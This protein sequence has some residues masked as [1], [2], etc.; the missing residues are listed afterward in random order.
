MKWYHII[1]YQ[2]VL[3]PVPLVAGDY[4]SIVNQ[5][6]PNTITIIG[7]SHKHPE[8]ITLF[9]SIISD[10]L[11][12]N[13]CLTVGLEIASNQQT[14]IDKLKQGRAVVSD[15]EIS[16]IIDHPAY[17]KMID[18]LVKLQKKNNCINLIAIDAGDDIDLRRDE[19]LAIHL[20]GQIGENPILVLLGGLHTLKKVDWDTSMTEGSPS[21]AEILFSQGFSVRS[22][23]QI[24]S[25]SQCT[26]E[27]RFIPADH[28]EL[29]S[30]LNSSFIS[31]MNA[32][33][34]KTAVGV[35]DG[36]IIWECLL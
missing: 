36:A 7:E 1:L 23:S 34:Y 17:R 15:I 18:D 5:L 21:V 24:W 25:G 10:H 31:L 30:L 35:V 12:Q 32:Y 3:F 33:E 9:H 6:K 28:P 19:W 27:N 13:K 4:S 2:F 20:A 26:S 22:Y 16:S 11:K 14:T 8:S 29:P